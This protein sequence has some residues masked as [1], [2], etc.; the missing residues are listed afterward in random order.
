MPTATGQ[1][2]DQLVGR[3]AEIDVIN[4]AIGRIADGRGSVLLFAG[5]PG[6]GKS[7]LART[8][9]ELANAGGV[10]VYWG[11]SWEAGGAPAY[12]PWTQLLRSL[13]A[14]QQVSTE[15]LRPL[16]QILPEVSAGDAPS[17]ELQP[18]Q[19]R[20][21]L[22][23]AVRTLLAALA[24]AS[25][26]MLVLEDLHAA[27]SDSLHLLHYVARHITSLPILIVGTFR[28]V[29]AR[30]KADTEALW[31]TSRDATVLKLS[32]LGEADIRE[33]LALRGGKTSDEEA[34]Q[35][36]LSTT[37]GNP[38]FLSELVE[39][40]AH[41]AD[42]AANITRLPDNVQQVIRQQLSL[43]PDA[44]VS[45][46]G[47]AAVIGR[48]FGVQ[49]LAELMHMDEAEVLQQLE[50]AID[51]TFLRPLKDGK[52]RF[53]HTLYRD[54]LYQDLEA[55]KREGL[56]LDCADRLRRLIDAGD[57][58]RWIALARHLQFAGPE[59]R[60][61]TIDALRK[62]AARAHAR[63]AFEDAAVLLHQALVA[64]GEGPKYEPLE[65]CGLLVDYASA[66][67]ITG[68]IEA[69]QKHCQDAFAIAKAIGDPQLMSEV[70]LTWGSQ[71]VVSK[72]DRTLIGALEECL[73]A[74]PSD[75]AATRSRVQARLAGALQP[76]RNPAEPMAMARE[77]IALART[78]G[79]EQ[80]LYTVLRFATSALMDFAP[81]N[82]RIQ[83][84][85]EYGEMAA[86]LG[87]V[88]QQFRS[89]QLMTIDASEIGDRA[90][91]EEA[92]NSCSS[93]ADRIDLPH[94]QWRALSGRAMQ[95]IIEGDFERACDLID[96]AQKVAEPIEDPVARATLSLQRFAL[97][98]E[99]DS[100]RVAT[101][102]QIETDLQAAYA[103]GMGEAEFFVKP[104]LAIYKHVGDESF[105]QQFVANKAIVERSFSGGDR[106]S[107]ANL[108]Q[109]A[110]LAGDA[111]LTASCY[112]ALIEYDDSCATLGLLG[113]C[114]C[115]PVTYW[116]AKLARGLNRLEEAA[117]HA[118]KAL[119]IATRMG[120]RPYIARIHAI[121]GD[122]A[123][124][125]G[126]DMLAADH[127]E[128]AAALIREL[129]LRAV[130]MVPSSTA[131]PLVAAPSRDLSIQQSGDVWTIVYDG[132]TATV[133]DAK[134]LHM[135]A[136]LIAKPNAEIHVLDLSGSSEVAQESDSGPLLDS[137]AREDY[138]RRITEL[139]EE[140]EEAESLADLGRA[141][142]LRAEIDFITRELSRAFGLG[143]RQRAAG[144]AAERARVNVR[145]RIKDAIGRI[146]EQAPEA[147]RY[148]ENTI[149]TGKYCKYAPM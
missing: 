34:V 119:A 74:L 64:F 123:R 109:V 116:L 101:I 49:E 115:G 13:I 94:Y 110:L 66:L 10:P 142:S 2:P 103:A 55:T 71:I 88:P 84:N 38:L 76:A 22:L 104:F 51:A 97:L 43:L 41:D 20:F 52:Y 23:E 4:D 140:L 3:N 147:G 48:E 79:D 117:A 21:Q 106:Y 65:R 15:Q 60:L 70:A 1:S 36:L 42:A 44:T 141:D 89:S 24:N 47:T 56:H 61:A 118:D 57:E 63:L 69:G 92:I 148:L 7:T 130:R 96:A 82:E 50:A 145:R 29:E 30:S 102:E 12:W 6:I 127:A 9:A 83:I 149:K 122:I 107:L 39:L 120:A 95:A 132:Q 14:E 72:V 26:F 111:D 78:T 143:G 129:G 100:P 80:V 46:L 134:G 19:A 105:A 146:S 32:H 37:A 114:W 81:P 137:Q 59:H 58:D 62:A 113:N 98:V 126:D 75:D 93:L 35:K 40:L 87:D 139:Q 108:G 91:I 73:A 135:L 5:E 99:W 131:P 125:A 27:D 90:A 67:M 121:A 54:V 112:D 28:D 17:S 136:R 8:G 16:A 33:Y 45:T 85:G 133:K 86:A 77:A 31:R 11:F 124:D 144:D 68:Q 18:D 25:P 53:A 128:K 138:R